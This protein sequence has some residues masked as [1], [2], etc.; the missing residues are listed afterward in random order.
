MCART[1][2]RPRKPVTG[3]WLTDW[4]NQRDEHTER[5]EEYR[6]RERPVDMFREVR[7]ERKGE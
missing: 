6:V 7:E 1:S 3:G 4:E 2:F 5:L